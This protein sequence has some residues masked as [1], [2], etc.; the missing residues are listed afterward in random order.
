MSF[1]RQ[2]RVTFFNSTIPDLL[3]TN[4]DTPVTAAGTVTRD[5]IGHCQIFLVY[6]SCD[7]RCKPSSAKLTYCRLDSITNQKAKAT[8]HLFLLILLRTVLTM[9]FKQYSLSTTILV[10]QYNLSQL[11][12][13]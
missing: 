3:A 10:F 13:V 12:S 2:T 1:K 4:S 7:T 11:E 8:G 9:N 6:S 5:L